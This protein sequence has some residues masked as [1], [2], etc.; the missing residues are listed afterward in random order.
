MGCII[1]VY[2]MHVR[3]SYNES[4]YFM[5]LIY[6]KNENKRI[7]WWAFFFEKR[8]KNILSYSWKEY[9]SKP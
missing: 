4:Y 5:Q 3:K 6:A 8:N 7:F 2:Y 9:N 1:K